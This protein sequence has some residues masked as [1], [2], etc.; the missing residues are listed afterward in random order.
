MACVYG[1]RTGLGLFKVQSVA[2][3]M[4]LLRAK[5]GLCLLGHSRLYMRPLPWRSA[6]RPIVDMSYS[7]HFVDFQGSSI[8]TSMKKLLVTQLSPDFRKA[9][10]LMPSVAVPVPGDGDLLIRNR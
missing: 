4:S 3:D 8:P 5:A 10:T 9:V 6:A 7:H 2:R 1:C